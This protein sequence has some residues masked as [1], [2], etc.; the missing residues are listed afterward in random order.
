MRLRMTAVCTAIVA[1]LLWMLISTSSAAEREDHFER[2]VRPLFIERCHKCHAGDEAKGGLRLDSR[3]AA[4]KG[5]DTGAA[6]VAG[7]PEESLLLQAVRHENGLE[8]PPDGKLTAA[9]VEAESVG[10]PGLTP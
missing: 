9:Q 1:T 10:L 8:M 2:H 4:L 5:G 7:K 3:T 6:I